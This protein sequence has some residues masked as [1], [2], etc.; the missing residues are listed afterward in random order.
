MTGLAD[1]D[2]REPSHG[3]KVALGTLATTA[4]TEAFFET[5]FGVEQVD[6]AVAAYPDWPTREAFIRKLFQEGPLRERILQ[7]SL[8]KHHT[9]AALRERLHLLALHWEKLAHR[10]RSQLI[11]F[12]TLRH[13]LEKAGCPTHPAAIGLSATRVSA[14]VFAAQMIRNRTTIL[15]LAAE[16]GRLPLLAAQLGHAWP[17]PPAEP[18]P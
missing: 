8:A 11:P 18:S 5:S 2:G 16:C 4:L 12:A 10:V 17:A 13:M 1:P 9:P 6:A 7:E 3:F 15:D 14:T